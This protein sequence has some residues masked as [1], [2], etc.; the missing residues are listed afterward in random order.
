MLNNKLLLAGSIVVAAGAAI[1]VHETQAHATGPAGSAAKPHK[2]PSVSVARANQQTEASSSSG[3]PSY[4]TPP[5]NGAGTGNP[6]LPIGNYFEYV[7]VLPRGNYEA[8]TYFLN[9]G[10]SSPGGAFSGTIY[11]I[12]QDGK[13]DSVFPFTGVLGPHGT[14]A[15]FTVTGPPT[16]LTHNGAVVY[17]QATVKTGDKLNATVSNRTVT[18]PGCRLY[19]YWLTPAV[20]GP[21]ALLSQMAND[22]A[23]CNFSYLGSEPYPSNNQRPITP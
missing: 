8:P 18:L 17:A 13:V 15:T 20:G 4:F 19:L 9:V 16:V 11:A 21:A 23:I 7:P 1:A 3:E 2:K 14:T 5:V 12:Y 6:S 22:P 10:Q